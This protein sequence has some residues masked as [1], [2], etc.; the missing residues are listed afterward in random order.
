[1]N[2]PRL[3][4]V[5]NGFAFFTP[6]PRS[7]QTGDDWDDAPY[8]HNAGE[9]YGDDITIVAFRADLVEPCDGHINS[10]WSVDDINAGAVAWLWQLGGVAIPAG[11]TVSEF[12]V[13]IRE[14]GG[15][16]YTLEH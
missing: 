6:R 9:P 10:A 14:A 4:Y 8:E 5:R 1:M 7:E 11:V 12:K 16:V 3:C 15:E 13:L 2:E